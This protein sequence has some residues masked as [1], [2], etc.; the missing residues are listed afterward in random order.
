MKTINPILNT[1]ITGDCEQVLKE[2]PSDSIDFVLTS[3]PYA[4]KR[5]YGNENSSISP[6]EYVEWFLPKGR[7]IYRVLKPTGSFKEILVTKLLMAFST[8]MYLNYCSGCVRKLVF[9]WSEII[10]GIIQ[11]H[12]LMFTHAV[13]MDGQRNPMN[14]VSGFPRVLTGHLS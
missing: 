11:R 3:P 5:D 6:D 4:D 12:H 8:Y 9:I 2:I 13:V 10:F 1:F 14:T 7:E